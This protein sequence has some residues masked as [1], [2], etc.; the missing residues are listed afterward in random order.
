MSSDQLKQPAG[1]A[2]H[3]LKVKGSRFIA[4][5]QRVVD[6]SEIESALQVIRKR[7]HNA[8]HHCYAWRLGDPEQ[9]SWRVNDDG[10]PAG[11]AGKPILQMLDGAH[12]T[13]VLAVVTRYFGGTKLG[14]G[15]LIHA[16]GDVTKETL[17][18]LRTRSFTPKATLTCTVSFEHSKLV[19]RLIE[20]YGATLLDQDY[21]NEV[22]LTFALRSHEADPFSWE[23]YE[24]SNGTIRCQTLD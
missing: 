1:M 7:E 5:I 3:E 9:G 8:T 13:N 4:D 11:T 18:L 17:P 16:Y 24:A 12:L 15:G 23:L 2:Q 19:Y 6:E 20:K 10:E 21:G 22:T 14:K